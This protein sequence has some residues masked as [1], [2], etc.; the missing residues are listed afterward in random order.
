MGQVEE[1]KAI[2]ED[3]KPILDAIESFRY[4][5]PETCDCDLE[6]GD[7]SCTITPKR[8]TNYEWQKMSGPSAIKGLIERIAAITRERDALAAEN[9]GL[10][11]ALR[12]AAASLL[13]ICNKAGR[14]EYMMDMVQVRG[15]ANS[16]ANVARSA[17][18]ESFYPAALATQEAKS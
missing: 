2:P 3:L 17:T 9:E 11:T 4:H 5:N 12:D 16:R 6:G 15:Y 10:L 18:N 13:T 7:E 14:D 8:P 1:L